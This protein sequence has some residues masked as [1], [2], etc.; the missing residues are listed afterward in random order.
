MFLLFEGGLSS[1]MLGQVSAC[2]MLLPPEA[3]YG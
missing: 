3:V 2:G 1:T